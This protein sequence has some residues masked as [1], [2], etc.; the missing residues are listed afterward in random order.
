MW[1]RYPGMYLWRSKYLFQFEK[2][3]LFSL[4]KTTSIY[5]IYENLMITSRFKGFLITNLLLFLFPVHIFKISITFLNRFKMDTKRSKT[6]T[7]SDI[8]IC[9]NSLFSAYLL[10]ELKSCIS[11]S[12]L[13]PFPGAKHYITAH[14]PFWGHLD[15]AEV[16]ITSWFINLNP[17]SLFR[18]EL[19]RIDMPLS[20]HLNP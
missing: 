1:R 13:Y 14:E 17:H 11:I 8:Y 16:N 20:I 18:F 12:S 19:L 15:Y 7:N 5:L 4:L 6:R 2:W 9:Y 10:L 3:H